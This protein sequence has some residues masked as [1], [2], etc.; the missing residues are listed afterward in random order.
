MKSK[1]Q[2]RCGG[3]IDRKETLVE[4]FLLTADVC[5]KC[6]EIGLPLESAK[7]LLRLQEEAKKIDSKR[8]IVKIGNS[9]GITL[10]HSSEKVGFRAGELAEIRLI[11]DGEIAVRVKAL[12]E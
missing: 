12:E 5:G 11:G 4:G 7:E 10:P 8:K 2:C 1:L 6:G 9:I 3:T